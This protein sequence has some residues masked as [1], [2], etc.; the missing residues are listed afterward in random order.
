VPLT[1]V[2]QPRQLMGRTAA[3]MLIAEARDRDEDHVHR[4]VVFTPE[5]VVRASSGLRPL[6]GVA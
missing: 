1:S 5:L 3:E 4:Q 6:N 2:A